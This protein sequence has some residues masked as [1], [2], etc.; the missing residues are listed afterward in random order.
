[1][2]GV[3]EATML[4]QFMFRR[5]GHN[6]HGWNS[7]VKIEGGGGNWLCLYIVKIGYFT[8]VLMPFLRTWYLKFY[9]YFIPDPVLAENY[10]WYIKF[11]EMMNPQVVNTL[12][13]YLS[14]VYSF[15]LRSTGLH[16]QKA[17]TS[18]GTSCHNAYTKFFCWLL[19]HICIL[20]AISH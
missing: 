18:L 6:A 17:Y 16:V 5:M 11:R 20:I 14:N 4:V 2:D 9:N 12:T 19:M 13:T 7:P 8:R 3:R 15:V 10:Y 1:M